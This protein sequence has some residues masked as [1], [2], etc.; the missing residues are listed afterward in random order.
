MG[1][2]YECDI[3][4]AR[5]AGLLPVWY[6]GAMDLPYAEDSSVLTVKAWEELRERMEGNL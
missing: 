1:D 4:G 5:N 3:N 6:I 2:Q